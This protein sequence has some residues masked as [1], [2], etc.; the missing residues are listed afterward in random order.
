MLYHDGF[1]F[2]MWVVSIQYVCQV[3]LD[4][5]IYSDFTTA[6]LTLTGATASEDGYEYRVK[7]NST[8]GAEEVISSTA[9]LT[10]VD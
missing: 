5:S 9:T 3:C 1:K 10:F 6:T 7:L 8:A 4:G 2:R